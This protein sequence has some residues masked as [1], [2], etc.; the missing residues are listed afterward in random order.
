MLTTEQL[1]AAR[2]WRRCQREDDA[3]DGVSG[4]GDVGLDALEA[5]VNSYENMKAE[6]LK[7]RKDSRLLD[8]VYLLQ[9]KWE[10]ECTGDPEGDLRRVIGRGR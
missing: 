4:T 2:H 5:A 1:R 10:D 6:V 7:L 3:A 8:E 9:S